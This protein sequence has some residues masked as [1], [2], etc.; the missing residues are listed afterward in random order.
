[1][2]TNMRERGLQ[3]RPFDAVI[4]IAWQSAYRLPVEHEPLTSTGS[5]P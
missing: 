5:P 2:L 3:R 4:V 1:M